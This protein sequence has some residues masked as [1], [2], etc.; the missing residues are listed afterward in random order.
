VG[1]AVSGSPIRPRFLVDEDLSPLIA[2]VLGRFQLGID[3]GN[4]GPALEAAGVGSKDEEFIPWLGETKQAWITHDKKAKKRHEIALKANR[5]TVL[6][7]SGTALAN[8][9]MLKI[10]VRVID[11]VIEKMKK[12]RGAIHFRAARRGGPTPTI[13]WAEHSQDQRKEHRR[14]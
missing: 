3:I 9:E 6:W 8:W 11:V 13:V 14:R 12:A 2:P 1:E 7:V 4:L 5:V 10:V